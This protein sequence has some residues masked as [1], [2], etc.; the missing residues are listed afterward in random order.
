MLLNIESILSNLI[1]QDNYNK[2]L[3]K[4]YRNALL[5]RLKNLFQ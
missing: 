5:D 3:D 1:D 2:H 4:S